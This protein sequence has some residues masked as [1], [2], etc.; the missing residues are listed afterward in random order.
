MFEFLKKV[1][2]ESIPENSL[3][4]VADGKSIPLEDVPDEVFSQKMM[5]EGIAI[6]LQG[7]KIVAPASGK[8]TLIY[9]TLHA[10]GMNLDNGMELIVHIGLDTVALKGKGFKKLAQENTYVKAGDPIISIDKEFIEKNGYSTVTM[11]IITNSDEYK[12]HL[13]EYGVVQKGRDVV[14][15]Y[16]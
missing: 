12:L 1:K 3:V 2:N 4:A 16:E 10:F 15:T 13:K 5:G 14:L 11:V 6:E 7:N 9:N 8:L